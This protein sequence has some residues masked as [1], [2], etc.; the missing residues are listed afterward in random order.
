VIND[1][2]WPSSVGVNGSHLAYAVRTDVA[3]PDAADYPAGGYMMVEQEI[4]HRAL[5][6]G[7]AFRNDRRAVWNVMSNICGQH[8]CRIYIKPVQNAED[9]RKA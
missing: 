3:V 1:T 7:P 2:D 4:V 8:E 9:G 6:S 5:H